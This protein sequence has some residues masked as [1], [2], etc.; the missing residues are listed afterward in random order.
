MDVGT[1]G[2]SPSLSGQGQPISGAPG[3]PPR[4]VEVHDGLLRIRSSD[5]QFRDFKVRVGGN[6]VTNQDELVKIA[7][8]VERHFGSDI[9][10]A[11]QQHGM[12]QNV[13]VL[14]S[15]DKATISGGSQPA[16][17]VT[18]KAAVL[19][20]TKTKT[21]EKSMSHVRERLEFRKKI[22]DELKQSGY[23]DA[24]LKSASQKVIDLTREYV[25]HF[26]SSCGVKLSSTLKLK[27]PIQLT[28]DQIVKINNWIDALKRNNDFNESTE[29]GVA[30]RIG[31]EALQ[32]IL[33]QEESDRPLPPPLPPDLSGTSPASAPAV[34]AIPVSGRT[35]PNR[36]LPPPP[37]QGPAS[38]QQPS[39]PSPPPPPPREDV[40]PG[41]PLFTQAP[42]SA[43]TSASTLAAS[44]PVNPTSPPS[45]TL[46]GG[47]SS[48]P[49]PSFVPES[50]GWGKSSA[51]S[52]SPA[53]SPR[54]PISIPK[55]PGGAPPAHQYPSP[56]P[57]QLG[58]PRIDASTS[59][60]LAAYHAGINRRADRETGSVED[61]AQRTEDVV[62]QRR[63]S[64]S[65]ER[66]GEFG[67]GF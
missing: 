31:C 64:W 3:V 17:E 12:A 7:I 63:S 21:V 61:V 8:I 55:S 29:N 48:S 23:P 41:A 43:P 53:S 16:Q 24:Q 52:S 60:A 58:S 35:P 1:G 10:D 34:A 50:G 5:G 4:S 27:D 25:G 66:D 28:D 9:G 30:L 49:R 47:F 32:K 67:R 56:P 15:G 37:I 59:P 20:G 36:P 45:L 22:E 40:Q 13:K 18:G 19:V 38:Q 2:V 6:L 46:P 57:R 42:A 26:E 11:L 33:G 44:A 54:Q 14:I 62:S 39:S 65:S 51:T